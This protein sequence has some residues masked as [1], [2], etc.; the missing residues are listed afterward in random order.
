VFDCR[1]FDIHEF[2]TGECELGADQ[3]PRMLMKLTYIED[4]EFPITSFKPDWGTHG[5][6]AGPIRNRE[7]AKYG[8][9]LLLIWDG[10]SRGSANMKQE[11]IK[12]GKPVYEVILKQHNAVTDTEEL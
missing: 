7:M 10:A 6:A 2:V 5:R 4:Y 11:M 3:I 8:D 12:L 1:H 9:A